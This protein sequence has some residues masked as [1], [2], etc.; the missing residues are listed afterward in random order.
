MLQCDASKTSI[1]GVCLQPHSVLV[2]VMLKPVMFFGRKL[3]A[4]E[5]RYSTTEREML[6]IVYAYL[7]CYHLVYGRHI[8][9]GTDHKPLVTLCKLKRPFD[10]L[11]R[12]LNH[13]MGVDYKLEYIP[14]HLNYLADFMSRAIFKDNN[15]NVI[16]AHITTLVSSVD[17][18]VE[19]AKDNEL[20][21]VMN[22]IINIKSDK[23]WLKFNRGDRW[24]RE[25]RHLYVFKS[26]LHHG[27][28]Q[29]VV[30]RQLIMEL[31]NSFYDSKFAGQ[32]FWDY[33][34]CH[35]LPV[36][37]VEAIQHG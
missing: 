21:A 12:L 13:L 34:V 4:T 19:Q 8:I 5:Q 28:S 10:R 7:A 24:L 6:A 29:I 31:L 15:T 9:F 17:W 11:G 23:E 33:P 18:V 35:I 16:S 1:E 2:T 20:V 37:L 14:G 36:L 25:K 32:S 30:P 3:T 26:V 22:C 27:S